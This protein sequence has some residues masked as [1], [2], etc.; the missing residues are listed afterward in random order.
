[1][2]ASSPRWGLALAD[3]EGQYCSWNCRFPRPGIGISAS[4]IVSGNYVAGTRFADYIIGPGSTVIG[5]TAVGN[6][7]GH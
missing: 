2:A 4:G 6:P 7:G 1:M 3:R 5:N